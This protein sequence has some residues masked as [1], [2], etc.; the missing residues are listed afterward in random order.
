[1]QI[2]PS[3]FYLSRKKCSDQ[4]WHLRC[5]NLYCFFEVCEIHWKRSGKIFEIDVR[6]KKTPMT[7]VIKVKKRQVT[8]FSVEVEHNNNKSFIFILYFLHISTALCV[9]R[10][11]LFVCHQVKSEEILPQSDVWLLILSIWTRNAL[12]VRWEGKMCHIQNNIHESKHL[13]VWKLWQQHSFC[14]QGFDQDEHH[15]VKREDSERK[16]LV[17]FYFSYEERSLKILSHYLQNFPMIMF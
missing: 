12:N 3:T 13:F 2:S 10:T 17:L 6:T 4:K 15:V 8:I 11:I 16:V 7:I 5:S 9:I 1:M 14:K